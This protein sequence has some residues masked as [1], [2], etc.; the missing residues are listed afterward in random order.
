MFID[1]TTGGAGSG[2]VTRVNQRHQYSGELGLVLNKLAKLIESPRVMLPPLA[3]VNR[4]S[5]TDTAQIFQSDSPASVFS[6]CNNA[7]ANRVIDICSKTSLFTR[8]LCEKSFASLR[9]FSLE[10]ATKFRMPF[11][12]PIDL[13]ARVNLPIGVGGNI[14]DAEV[15]SKKLS[16]VAFRRL[17][18]LTGLEEVEAAISINQVGFPA[19]MVKHFQLPVSDR[20]RNLQPAIKCPDRNGFIRQL[21]G[22]DTLVISDAPMPIESPLETPVGFVGIRHLRQHANHNLGRK[23]KSRAQVIVQK[24]VK[25]VLAKGL[26]FPR[27]LTDIVGSIIHSLQRLQQGLVLLSRRIQ[28]NLSYQLHTLIIAQYSSVEKEVRRIPPRVLPVVSFA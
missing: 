6:L 14:D 26:R 12:K 4:N 16:G 8:T 3:L 17:L 27:L 9:T 10:F 22:E 24:V 20:K 15:N 7:L 5:V 2:R 13:S 23:V 18:N 1:T 28:L 19:E 21:P 25:V 11:S